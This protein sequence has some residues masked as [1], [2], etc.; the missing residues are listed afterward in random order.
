MWNGH[1]LKNQ[2]CEASANGKG[3]G[4]AEGKL[5]QD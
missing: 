3:R 4:G 2:D 5:S 1:W